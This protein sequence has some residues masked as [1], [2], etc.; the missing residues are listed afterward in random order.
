MQ[1]VITL[2]ELS[3][4]IIERV[5]DSSCSKGYRVS[6]K[7]TYLTALG[8]PNAGVSSCAEVAVVR[9]LFSGTANDKHSFKVLNTV[10]MH[11][12]EAMN[13]IRFSKD[14]SK[15]M[16]PHILASKSCPWLGI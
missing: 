2:D 4:T 3:D 15:Y 1:A 14:R 13:G 16:N 9:I 7:P 10:Q 11:V 12:G 5:T 6:L 8:G